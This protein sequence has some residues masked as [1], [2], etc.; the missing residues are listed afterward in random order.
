[1]I[2]SRHK[3]LA[4]V[5][6]GIRIGRIRD[7]R[8]ADLN[9]LDLCSGEV[10]LTLEI[11]KAVHDDGIARMA[12]KQHKKNHQEFSHNL[13]PIFRADKNPFMAKRLARREGGSFVLSK[14]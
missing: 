2:D 9:E 6:S 8:R 1:M 4:E 12:Y 14:S 7:R 3:I 10:S 13:P 11:T 5:A